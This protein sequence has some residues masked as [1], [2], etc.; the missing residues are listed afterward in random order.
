MF[1]TNL[2]LRGH[3]NWDP[4]SLAAASFKWPTELSLRGL[5][6]ICD[7]V[8]PD[9]ITEI[10][11]QVI[12]PG[13]L[14]PRSGGIRR[15]SRS[16]EG[17]AFQVSRRGPGLMVGDLL[18]SPAS[19]SP[20]LVVDEVMVGSMVSGKFRGFRP[21]DG[22]SLWLWAVLNSESG[23]FARSLAGA[24]VSPSTLSAGLRYLRVPVP[25]APS[26]YDD[27]LNAVHATTRIAEDEGRTTWWSTADL[28]EFDWRTALATPRPEILNEGVPL[29]ELC[30]NILRG[31]RVHAQ[32]L[33][34][35]F[36]AGN[37][38]VADI[39]FLRGKG[40]KKWVSDDVLAASRAQPGDV[41]VSAVGRFP[42]AVVADSHVVVDQN[43]YLLRV[44]QPGQ[45]HAV[46]RYLNGTEGFGLRQILL[47]G[48]VIPSL[49]KRDL[50][51]LPVSMAQLRRLARADE[52]PADK[53]LSRRLE[54]LLWT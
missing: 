35:H 40:A 30:E 17:S 14:D 29:G 41:L 11:A 47:S 45:A 36:R 46:A 31:R 48:P 9:A 25:S 6:E 27:E 34:P 19:R 33:S 44:S 49:N 50:E 54:M 7:S 42:Y 2:D 23:Q 51:R 8:F 3:S 16:F 26:S 1:S 4:G 53:P 20:V 32:E 13:G 43:V 18:V 22:L 10:G 21:T 52:D 37:T 28:R 12:T 5:H 15:R 39:A 24:G 38:P